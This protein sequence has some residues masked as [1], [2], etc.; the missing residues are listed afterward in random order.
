MALVWCS[1]FRE[2]SIYVELDD[3]QYRTCHWA[4][5]L[6]Y[7]ENEVIARAYPKIRFNLGMRC[8]FRAEWYDCGWKQCCATTDGSATAKL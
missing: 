2:S 5:I 1:P 4:V 7:W 6:G 8:D 3:Q